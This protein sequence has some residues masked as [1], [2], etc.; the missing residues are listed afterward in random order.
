MPREMS[1]RL[2]PI[3]RLGIP[4]ATSSHLD[5]AADLGA[6]IGE[7]LAHLIHQDDGQ[8]LEVLLHQVPQ[9]E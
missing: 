6:G 4:V 5:A 3:I 2:L 8:L 7:R 9:L 1:S